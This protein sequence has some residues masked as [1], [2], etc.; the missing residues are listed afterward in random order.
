MEEVR[1]VTHHIKGQ[2]RITKVRG[3]SPI[4]KICFVHNR[5]N[6]WRAEA[7]SIDLERE[8]EELFVIFPTL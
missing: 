6:R 3:Q 8:V 5:M 7:L 1:A 4:W 2:I